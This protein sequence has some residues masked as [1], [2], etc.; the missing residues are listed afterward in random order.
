MTI[1]RNHSRG[2]GRSANVEFV[3]A[4][5]TRAL[6]PEDGYAAVT[7]DVLSNLLTHF[8]WEVTREYFVN[9][10]GPQLDALARGVYAR[11]IA[12]HEFTHDDVS[13]LA[14]KVRQRIDASLLGAP[15]ERWLSA[16]RE[17]S[18]DVAL[19]M[20]RSDLSV[21]G[22]TF[23]LFSRESTLGLGLAREEMLAQFA[24]R[25]LLFA[26]DDQPLQTND[27]PPSGR[28]F[29]ATDSAGDIRKRPL[30][31][32]DGHPTYF[33]ND[34]A[35]HAGKIS[36]GYA[37]LI[38]VFR[39][40]HASYAPGLKAAVSLL[41]DGDAALSVCLIDPVKPG[42]NNAASPCAQEQ[43]VAPSLSE[44]LNFYGAT[45]LRHLYLSHVPGAPLEIGLD[46]ARR[47]ALQALEDRQLS[48]LAL[49][50][51]TGAE[52]CAPAPCEEVLARS[53][54][55]LAPGALLAHADTIAQGVAA[56]GAIHPAD[57][58]ALET[59]RALL[60]LESPDV[61]ST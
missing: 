31:G 56:S 11:C 54:D 61:V 49:P 60:G 15:E 1:A 32:G 30:T 9:D 18:I 55:D 58:S 39:R 37:L 25:G 27:L 36:R 4:Y 3:S 29:L 45:R 34:L 40:D 28:A 43:G 46:A 5:P 21:L 50:E 2:A 41:S 8:G 20:I 59:C 44:L 47:A 19:D 22:V 24:E 7:G 38:D 53:L 52:A 14:G 35:Y 13:K 12:P 48:A 42:E 26:A 57:R 33:A 10:T 23:D 17:A 6:R 16:L 51:D